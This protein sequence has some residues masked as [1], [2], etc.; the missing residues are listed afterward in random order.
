LVICLI[1]VPSVAADIELVSSTSEGVTVQLVIPDFQIGWKEAGGRRFQTILFPGCSFT[2]DVGEPRLPIQSTLI[3][4][5]ADVQFS[6]KVI[7]ADS[8]QQQVSQI[9]P[10]PE[11]VI[12]GVPTTA[13]LSPLPS[14]GGE[15]GEVE[16]GEALPFPSEPAKGAGGLGGDGSGNVEFYQ[17]AFSYKRNGFFPQAVAEIGRTGFIRDVRV[18]P[19]RLNPF[20]Y[21]P[22]A[23]TVKLYHHLVVQIQFHTPPG[24][25]SSRASSQLAQVSDLRSN[26]SPAYEQLLESVLVNPQHAKLWRHR[27]TPLYQTPQSAPPLLPAGAPAYKIIVDGDGMYHITYR[28]M[29]EA[30][31]P[32]GTILPST[33]KLSNRGRAIPI[34]VRG[35]SDGKFDPGDEI[36]FYGQRNP[37]EKTYF[38]PFSDEN[39]YWLSWGGGQ[40]LRMARGVTSSDAGVASAPARVHRRFRSRAHFEEDTLFVRLALVNENSGAEYQFV[41]G[42]VFNRVG[43]VLSLP[44][45]PTDSWYWASLPAPSVRQFTFEL[46]DVAETSLHATVRVMLRGQTD[47]PAKPD[48]HTQI[49]LNGQTMLEDARW[50]GQSEHLFES[51][52]ISQF[53][54]QNGRNTISII[55]PGDTAAG[56]LDQ[57]LLNYFEIEYW[58]NFTAKEDTLPFS[59]P[60]TPDRP[61]F[62]VVLS[63][64][65][66][67][68]VEL[69][70]IDGTRF[71][72]LNSQPDELQPGTYQVTFQSTSPTQGRAELDATVQYIA[73]TRDR[74]R[75]PKAIVRDA[76]SDLRQSNGA[77]YLII[78]HRSL[79]PGVDD[80]ANWRRQQGLRVKVIDVQDIYD[81]FNY[82]IFN[83]YAIR[84]FLA[85]AYQNWQPPAPTFV[86]LVGDANLDY[87]KGMNFV[88][89]ILVQTPKYGAAASDHEFVTFVGDD[90]FPDMLIGRL[91]VS[92]LIDLAIMT[93]R[94]IQYEKTP[95]IG[96]WR[97]RLL[98]LGGVGNE[99]SLQSDSLIATK[100]PSVFEPVR[101]YAND[102][103]SPLYGSAN[104]VI[105]GFERGAAIVNFI[106][107]G[108]GSIWSDNRMMGLEDIPLLENGRRLPFVVS[109]TCFTGYFDNPH[110]SSLAEEMVRAKN[111]GAIAFFGNT[112]LGWLLGDFFFNQEIFDS[113]FRA[114]SRRIGEIIGNSKIRF[115]TKN[116]GYIDV[117]VMFTLFGDPALTLGL[118]TPTVQITT[119][120]SVVDANERLLISGEMA[121]QGFT[122]QA[123]IT[124]W[125]PLLNPS[126]PVPSSGED[127]PLL[128]QE[129]V[130][131]VGGKFT[132]QFVLPQSVQ[133]GVGSISVYARNEARDAV[134]HATFSISQPQIASVRL[135]PDPVPP[136][137][138]VDLVAEVAGKGVA[139]SVTLFWSLDSATWTQIPMTLQTGITYRT[140]RPIPPRPSGSVVSFYI[141]TIDQRGSTAKTPIQSYRVETRPDLTVTEKD[142]T[143]SMQPPLLLS[144]TIR[145]KGGIPAQG[146][147]VRFFDGS[148][149]EGTQI[150]SD[151]IITEIPPGETG[152]ASVPW[153]PGPGTHQVTVVI[154]PPSSLN[155]QGVLIEQ[156]ELN[157]QATKT[158]IGNRFFLTPD[159]A[160]AIQST[161]GNLRLALAPGGI[162][163]STVLV[164]DGKSDIP[165]VGQ[166]DLR[167]AALPGAPAGFAYQLELIGEGTN[168]SSVKREVAA[169]LTF[170][171]D[172]AGAPPPSTGRGRS[173]LMIYRQDQETKKWIAVGGNPV[174][175]AQIAVQ[176]TLP[177]IYALIV[178]NDFTPPELYL[179]VEHQSFIDGDFVSASP[180]LSATL[181]DANGLDLRPEHIVLIKNREIVPP[182]EYAI[183]VSPTNSNLAFL[184]YTPTLST[185]T[186]QIALQAQ[187]ANTNTAQQEIQVRV[188]GKF[189]VEKVA[190]YPNPFTPGTK[191]Q[192][193]TDFAYLLTSDADKVTL[194]VYTITGRLIVSID[195][196][197]GFA[198]Y[199]EYH[200]DGLDKDKEEL[201]NGVYI[202]RI[203]AEK[204]KE[205]TENRGKLVVLR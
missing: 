184:S 113:I 105:A 8:T 121:E 125:S 168:S 23:G 116:P 205:V 41:R 34:F 157:N 66:N 202:Y 140:Q 133:S 29:R 122:G 166:P 30:G 139:R 173:Q 81:E 123:D 43:D 130:N 185:G 13:P 186:H 25:P 93:N 124:V 39:V 187:D 158:F 129:T 148:F 126:L 79:M 196:L 88:P 163:S 26:E 35:E 22:A 6:L 15:G 48:H 80:L 76:P 11:M 72:E 182:T 4:I 61:Q 159:R 78:T 84:D 32:V 199:N 114:N 103:A 47:T 111:G 178:N 49:W 53:F 52:Q 171:Y 119:T 74:L 177:G 120:P 85:Y 146:V 135:E 115:L 56:D 136:D 181:S 12:R 75:E 98:M 70:T 89:S 86:V 20:Q 189:A 82:G 16:R 100:V 24:A 147:P 87:R 175:E 165:I 190:N 188:S 169:T 44:P 160:T 19:L 145:N 176:V 99:F 55:I 104:E 138:P 10:T 1:H 112:G 154:D 108:G 33:L 63:N 117:A 7:Q 83:P 17:D 14:R 102:P 174:S 50:D 144:A 5:P 21:N 69:Y 65:S 90:A 131:V 62:R 192:Q 164:L 91:P 46:P 68:E 9:Y 109:M 183:S 149:E 107:H 179:T 37:G 161:D 96:P 204:G 127:R 67:P 198:G 54:L 151:Q 94:I 153:Q 36:I 73:L 201:S 134:G 45:L 203:I 193:G 40:G 132:T 18:L 71:A 51:A 155:P 150:G 141:E 110:G 172:P 167:Y 58:R 27:L 95:E 137:Q 2:T 191:R 42:G 31:I 200:W 180:V 77:D 38:D 170:Q 195:K 194:K 128:H 197:D 60:S 143:W 3:A 118:P 156:N 162:E 97:K 64:F 101:L 152:T 106:G 59:I 28:L 92:N 57:I 142:I